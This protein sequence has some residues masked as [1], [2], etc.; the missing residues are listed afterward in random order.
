MAKQVP[1]PSDRE[2][3]TVQQRERRQ[4]L[5]ATVARGDANGEDDT[6]RRSSV[7]AT[8]IIH[9]RAFLLSSR[10]PSRPGSPNGSARQRAAFPFSPPPP[11]RGVA[12]SPVPPTTIPTLLVLSVP[13]LHQPRRKEG[14]P[15]RR[16]RALCLTQ[17]GEAPQ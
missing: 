12:S 11:K 9:S 16:S 2:D 3:E 8:N 5:D 15:R 1:A 6:L 17:R 7:A 14:D 10:G 13:S 4:R